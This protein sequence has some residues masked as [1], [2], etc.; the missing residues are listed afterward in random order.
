MDIVCCPDKNYVMPTGVMMCSLCENNRNEDITFH[1]IHAD[2]DE[3]DK[4]SLAN[5]AKQY[6]KE[7]YFYTVKINRLPDIILGAEGQ[8]KLPLAAYFRLCLTEF[9]P[10]H[11]N[12]VLY[13]DGD[14]IIRSSL[15]EL[16]ETNIDGF[17]LAGVPDDNL[18]NGHI[19][20]TYNQLKYS[21]VLGYFNSG[22]LLINLVYWRK[23]NVTSEFVM[24]I[25]NKKD[26]FIHHDQDILNLVFAERKKFIPLKYNLMPGFLLN[27]QYR[28]IS[29]EYN[30]E[31]EEAARN[32]IVVH[33]TGIKPWYKE[34]HHPYKKEFFR[35]KALTKWKDEPLM[36][37][38]SI[39]LNW[40]KSTVKRILINLHLINNRPMPSWAYTSNDLVS[41]KQ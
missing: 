18:F 28:K 13:L 8:Q 36:R 40:I 30:V 26:G 16:W 21:P 20:Q 2:L 12:K 9:L 24:V 14:I 25:N 39:P 3:N 37:M 6:G 7:I 1:I 17:A 32:P 4:E 10:T 22:V 5:I 11:I 33:Y 23:K 29:W 35:Y 31:I 41:N 38:H 27:P 19:E 34:C 15:K